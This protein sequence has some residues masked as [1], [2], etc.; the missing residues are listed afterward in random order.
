MIPTHDLHVYLA[1]YANWYWFLFFFLLQVVDI[2]TSTKIISNGGRELNPV[3]KKL[4]ARFGTLK[5]LVIAKAPLLLGLCLAI[6]FRQI[7]HYGMG[8][9][10]FIYVVICGWNFLQIKRQQD[11]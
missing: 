5:A 2:F 11:G 8:L 3:I 1:T 10:C 6:F 7:N 4:S 9:I